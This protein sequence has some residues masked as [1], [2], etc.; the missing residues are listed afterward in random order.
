VEKIRS[1][2]K[3]SEPDGKEDALDVTKVQ[4]RGTLGEEQA[5]KAGFLEK[6][7]VI[8]SSMVYESCET[9]PSKESDL[10]TAPPPGSTYGFQKLACEYFAKG[11]WEQHGLPY[12]IIRPFNAV[13]ATPLSGNTIAVF[14]EA[15]M[16]YPIDAVVQ[17]DVSKSSLNLAP[18]EL[19]E[20][21]E[22]RNVQGQQIISYAFEEDVQSV[23]VLL[24]TDGRN[25]KGRIEILEG[26]NNIKQVMEYYSSNGY[27][28]PF[29]AVI[30]TPGPGNVVRIVN[31]NTIE[32]PFGAIVEP[33]VV[34]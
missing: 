12:T 28:R 16:E 18:A 34:S 13:V 4:L 22:L 15:T 8:S 3:C 21:K 17:G 7:V 24:K 27:K 31:E 26:P 25:L 6:I 5:H 2:E 1:D 20:R 33:Y 11:A 30:Q 32:Y 19:L 10:K 9:F 23:E 29:Y 14:N